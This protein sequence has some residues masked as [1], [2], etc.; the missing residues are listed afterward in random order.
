MKER[1]IPK[2]GAKMIMGR[3]DSDNKPKLNSKNWLNL[4]SC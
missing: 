1:N 2:E 4:F 3:D